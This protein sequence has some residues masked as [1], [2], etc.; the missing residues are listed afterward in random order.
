MTFF[1][2]NSITWPVTKYGIVLQTVKKRMTL[3]IQMA[4]IFGA[5]EQWMT[6]LVQITVIFGAVWTVLLLVLKRDP[7]VTVAQGLLEQRATLHRWNLLIEDTTRLASSW[8]RKNLIFGLWSLNANPHHTGEI[9]LTV[10]AH[11]AYVK[12]TLKKFNIFSSEVQIF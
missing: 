7:I 4:M 12:Y 10:T 8:S 5:C 1:L 9:L 11:C 2:P 3:L 6:L